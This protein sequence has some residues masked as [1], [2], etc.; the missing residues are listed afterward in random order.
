MR[1]VKHIRKWEAEAFDKEALAP[2]TVP[3]RRRSAAHGDVGTREA[4]LVGLPHHRPARRRPRRRQVVVAEAAVLGL[5]RTA[6][7]ERRR[8]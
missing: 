7:H 4:D 3:I 8:S 5:T 6:Q 1:G 2:V